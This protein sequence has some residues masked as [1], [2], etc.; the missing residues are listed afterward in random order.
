MLYILQS[1]SNIELGEKEGLFIANI[2]FQKYIIIFY[3]SYLQIFCRPANVIQFSFCSTYFSTLKF[4]D[5]A[6]TNESVPSRTSSLGS[7]RDA[8]PELPGCALGKYYR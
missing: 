2:K 3:P 1:T 8:A 7:I 6:N 4:V 5:D